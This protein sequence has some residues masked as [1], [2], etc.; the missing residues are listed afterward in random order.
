MV[1]ALAVDGRAGPDLPA[2]F[3]IPER[4]QPRRDRQSPLPEEWSEGAEPFREIFRE[5]EKLFK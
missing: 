4:V 5:I 3:R 1:S 2:E